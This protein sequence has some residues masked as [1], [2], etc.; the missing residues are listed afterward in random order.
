MWTYELDK[1]Y[2][3]Y[4]QYI[5]DFRSENNTGLRYFKLESTFTMLWSLNVCFL[6]GK[7]L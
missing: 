6:K 3:I 7:L 5:I 2:D 1:I 4:I